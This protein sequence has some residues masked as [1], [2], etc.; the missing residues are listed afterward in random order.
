MSLDIP[1]DQKIMMMAKVVGDPGVV[2]QALQEQQKLAQPRYGNVPPGNVLTRTMPGAATAESMFS[3]PM[4]PTQLGTGRLGKEPKTLFG[5]PADQFKAAYDFLKQFTPDAPEA[6][7]L[8]GKGINPLL[9][10]A[11]LSKTKPSTLPPEMEQAWMAN[12]NWVKGVIEAFYTN[13]AIGGG[14]GEADYEVGPD[15]V[16]RPLR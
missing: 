16:L 2:I 3:A 14:G 9:I 12:M 7:D 11:S 10:L 15:G 6:V 5:Q 13:S 8:T 4:T 1:T